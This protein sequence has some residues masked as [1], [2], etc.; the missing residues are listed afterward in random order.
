MVI[1]GAGGV[2]TGALADRAAPAPLTTRDATELIRARRPSG[3]PADHPEIAELDLDLT[4]V[5][6]DGV[7]TVD[8]RV[9]LVPRRR[10]DPYLRRLR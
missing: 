3:P 10:W 4:I 7:V 8:A 9:R 1:F 5:R 2:E 6:P